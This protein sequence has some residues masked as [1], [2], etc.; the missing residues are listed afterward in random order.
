MSDRPTE[1]CTWKECD[2]PATHKQFA[3]DG[4]T[5]WANLCQAHHDELEDACEKLGA[6]PSRETVARNIR[7]W[8]LAQGGSQA[9][10]ARI[11]T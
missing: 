10:A 8:I 4:V 3:N 2:R 7:C 9:A 5:V 6:S 1:C 11:V